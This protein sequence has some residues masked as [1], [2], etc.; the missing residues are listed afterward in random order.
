MGKGAP[1]PGRA[2]APRL[3]AVLVHG[4]AGHPLHGWRPWLKQELESRGWSVSIP[5][6]PH[7]DAPVCSEWVEAISQAV[8]SP[9]SSCAL[10]GHSLG[11]MAILRY[12]DT[13]APGHAVGTVV[14]VA[15]FGSDTARPGFESFIHPPL[16]WPSLR[17]R[18]SRFVALHSDNDRFI[19]LS[20]G[21]F[22]HR[23]LGAE[24]IVQKGMGHFSS[25]E[26]TTR[27]PVA[28]EKLLDAP[29]K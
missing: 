1:S 23:Q 22:L 11:C 6:M 5:A 24:L 8:G 13:L 27:L 29:V 2:S 9:V 18:A 4:F 3:R 25:S 21:E 16:N 7:A 17:S 10:V 26:G 12:L 28:L 14:L 15:G 19:P 20:E